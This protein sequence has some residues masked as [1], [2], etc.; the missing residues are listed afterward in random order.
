MSIRVS[1]KYYNINVRT[2]MDSAGS[3]RRTN[4]VV[5]NLVDMG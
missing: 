4:L 2:M 3:D 1:P 5:E